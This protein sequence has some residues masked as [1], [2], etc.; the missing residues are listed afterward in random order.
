VRLG[1]TAKTEASQKKSILDCATGFNMAVDLGKKLVFPGIVQT[2]LRPD[3]VLW[4]ETGKK[5]FVI[6]LTVL[7]ETRCK[8]AYERK[9]KYTELLKQ[10]R[11]QGWHTRL[12][13]M[14]VGG[15]G[16][17]AQSVCR[18]MTAVGT[19]GRDRRRAIQKLSQA[20]EWASSWLWLRR[21]ETSWMRST[22]TP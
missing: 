13:T 11:H 1:E 9:A 22:S 15:R 8:E 12:F 3:I 20:A 14:E 18:L 19:T 7:W 10:C 16:F 5:L 6:E 4:S 21:E 17:C 2:N